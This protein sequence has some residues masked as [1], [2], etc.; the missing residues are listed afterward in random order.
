M[1]GNKDSYISVRQIHIKI[2]SLSVADSQHYL[3]DSLLSSFPK[4]M[5]IHKIFAFNHV[6]SFYFLLFIMNSTNINHL[7]KSQAVDCTV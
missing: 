5:L 6:I 4:V 3:G 1:L 7:C 2:I